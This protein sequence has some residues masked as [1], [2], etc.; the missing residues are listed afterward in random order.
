MRAWIV[1]WSPAAEAALSAIAERDYELAKRI[2]ADV[3]RFVQSF[4]GDVGRVLDGH[5]VQLGAKKMVVVLRLEPN[6]RTVRVMAIA[7]RRRGSPR[8][9]QSRRPPRRRAAK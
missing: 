1:D 2:S 5:T 9:L 7:P 6:T 3:Q 8:V 4:E